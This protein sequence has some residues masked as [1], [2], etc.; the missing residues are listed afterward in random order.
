MR[1]L[2]AIT[3]L[4]PAAGG[5]PMVVARLA[6]AQAA[7]GHE[8]AVAAYPSPGREEAIGQS[9]QRVPHFDRMKVREL[10]R[11]RGLGDRIL[12]G[13]GGRAVGDLIARD[14]IDVL[15]L[16]GVWD[17]LLRAAAAAA[18]RAG[19]P[20][21]VTPHGMLDPWSLAQSRLKKR[22]ALVLAYRR[23]LDGAAFLHALN[24]DEQ[25]LIGP[26]GLRCP[27]R[28]IPNGVFI[29]EFDH[30]PSPGSFQAVRPALRGRPF[31]LFLSRLHTKKGLDY[32]ADAMALLAPRTPDLQLVVAGPDDGARAPFEQQVARLGLGERVHVVGPIYGT[33]KLAALAD[34]ACFC[35]PSRQEGFSMAITEALACGLPAVISAACHFPEVAEAGAGEVVD[36]DPAAV[37]DAIERVVGDETRRR[38]MGEAGR[39]LVRTRYTWP[40]IAEQ[41]VAAYQESSRPQTAAS[42]S[43]ATAP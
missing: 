36:L 3:T 4:D 17:P 14:G 24:A 5:P 11:P 43:S 25:R 32:L 19:K 20:Y 27:V 18:K 15:H 10:P 9:F 1:I 13:G 23:M 31:V 38:A 21:V 12:A 30:L 28:V 37:A 33:D 34:A 8:V 39:R 22:V 40:K 2:H 16:H 41:C 35:L 42:P 29:E 26:M 6:A 7:L